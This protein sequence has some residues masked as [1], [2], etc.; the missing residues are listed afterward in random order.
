MINQN[1]LESVMASMDLDMIFHADGS[2]FSADELQVVRTGVLL[3]ASEQLEQAM[4]R[5][6]PAPTSPDTNTATFISQNQRPDSF[7]WGGP[8]P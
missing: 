6:L 1:A 3:L 7:I 2:Q 4:R 5:I 8:R